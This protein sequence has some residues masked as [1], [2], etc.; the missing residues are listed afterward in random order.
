IET[1]AGIA[2]YF[3]VNIS[4]PNTP[5]LRDLQQGALFDELLA[6]VLDARERASRQGRRAPLLI[7]I[8]PDLSLRE[9]DDVVRAARRRGVDG[10][11]VGNTP[12][13]RP[14]SLRSATAQEAGGLSGRPLFTLSTRMLAEAYVRLEGA[15]P[16]VGTGGIDSGATAL[17][18]IRAGASLVQL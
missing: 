7:K 2:S 14:P 8:A 16:L 10:M 12:V 17:A 15:F 5:G 3:T 1:F 9:L 11:L 13:A 4:S 6:R 18:K